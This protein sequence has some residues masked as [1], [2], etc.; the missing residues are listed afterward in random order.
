MQDF[1]FE[2]TDEM[3]EFKQI[4]DCLGGYVGGS[5]WEAALRGLA[6]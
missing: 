3:H 2:G 5:R 4:S 1:S 6:R